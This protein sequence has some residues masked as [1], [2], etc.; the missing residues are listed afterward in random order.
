M[1]MG[2]RY[3]DTGELKG[4]DRFYHE[5]FL[6]LATKYNWKYAIVVGRK[7]VAMDNLPGEV[8]HTSIPATTGE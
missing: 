5:S 4:K 3:R 8:D 6:A 2:T 1:S 7:D